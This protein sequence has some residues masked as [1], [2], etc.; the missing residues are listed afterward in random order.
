VLENKLSILL[1][2]LGFIGPEIVLIGALLLIIVI[3]LIFKDK[4]YSLNYFFALISSLVVIY[5]DYQQLTSDLDGPLA[6]VLNMLELSQLSIFWKLL[7]D[8]G[9]FLSL[10]VHYKTAQAKFRLE[11]IVMFFAI[12][13]GAHLLIMSSNLLMVYLSIELMSIAAYISTTYN[14][15]ADGYESAIKYLLFG[16]VSSAIMIYGISMIYIFTGTLQF[17]DPVFIEKLLEVNTFSIAAAGVMILLG[18]LFKLSA[19]PMHIWAP[20]VYQSAPIPTVNFFSIVPK[21]AGLA[22]V[23]TW[24]MSIN[25]F[26]L[27]SINWPQIIGFLAVASLVVGNFAAL[28]QSNVKRMMAYSSIAQSGFLLLGL[29][30]FSEVGLNAILFYASVYLVMNAAA[31]LF[32]QYFENNFQAKDFNDYKGL[33]KQ[34]PYLGILFLVVLIS[35]TGLPPTAGF[36][37]KF[38]IF[39]ALWEYYSAT[40]QN[41]ILFVFAF[42]LI[43]AVVSL[44]YYLKIP[45]FMIFKETTHNK[46]ANFSLFDNF[47]ST[48]LVLLLFI[49]FFKPEWLMNMINSVNFAL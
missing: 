44:V 24:V 25:L 12:T 27:G 20:D 34:C 32:I 31:F 11:S 3:D 13:I 38:F 28:W 16:G 9:L 36:M 4:V 41:W 42:G 8:L 37:A 29:A 46:R 22:F 10:L 17:G 35:L 18:A 5:F 33:I 47:L 1:E 14:Q 2:S 15:K 48:I 23:I 40:D 39:S 19:A 43:N 7:I 45:Y 30:A 26:G 6:L 21:L 49:L